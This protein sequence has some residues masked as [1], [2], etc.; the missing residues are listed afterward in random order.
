MLSVNT[1]DI[2][3]GIHSFCI[4][5]REAL[6][7]HAKST[8]RAADEV[9]MMELAKARNCATADTDN[10]SGV[11]RNVMPQVMW[12]VMSMEIAAAQLLAAKF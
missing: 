6:Y 2:T 4:E 10:N 1:G 8:K 9:F 7:L 5:P 12:N 11:T 3:E